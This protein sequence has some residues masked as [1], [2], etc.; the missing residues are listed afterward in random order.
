MN[1]DS[2]YA[3]V[4]VFED[5]RGAIALSKNLV[6]RQRCKHV[7]IK[8]HFVRSPLSDGKIRIEFCPTVDMVADV[9]T[10]PVTIVRMD[11][12]MFFMFGRK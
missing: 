3:P 7:D 10:K 1:C 4:T 8:Y 5:N 2:E 9:L 12:F 11:K 6:L